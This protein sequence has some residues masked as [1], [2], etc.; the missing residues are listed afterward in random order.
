MDNDPFGKV[1]LRM[2][3]YSL[4]I[5]FGSMSSAADVPTRGTVSVNGEGVVNAQ[6]DM[7]L[8]TLGAITEN[9][10]LTAAQQA[11][12]AAMTSVINGLLQMGIPNENIKTVQYTIDPVYDYQDGKQLLRGYRVTHLLQVTIPQIP[13]VGQIVDQAVQ[14]GA[15]SVS[16]IQ[17]TLAHPEARYN[18]ALS[19]AIRNAQQKA[20]TISQT[21][22]APINLLPQKIRET[23]QGTPVPLEPVAYAKVAAA[24]PIEAG[25][26]QVKATINAQFSIEPTSESHVFSKSITY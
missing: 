10:D 24:T 22:G 20:Y 7:A 4:P 18:E 12:S 21:I 23:S 14:N 16:N 25:Q 2:K 1:G 5:P 15:N 11:N 8:V 9:K 13:L 17:F 3:D 19:L 6:P 26:L